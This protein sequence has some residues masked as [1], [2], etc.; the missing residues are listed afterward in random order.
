MR[1]ELLLVDN[2]IVHKLAQLDLLNETHSL[3]ESNYGELAV[4]ATLRYKFCNKHPAK[5]ARAEQKFGNGAIDNIQVFLDSNVNEIDVVVKDEKLLKAMSSNSR[6]LD[7]GEMQLLQTLLESRDDLMLTGDKKFLKSLSLN[8]DI[9]LYLP[10]LVELF[11]CFE[12]II[13]FIINEL[14]FTLVKDKYLNALNSGLQIDSTLRC[15]FEGRDKAQEK[16]V[17]DNLNTYISYLDKETCNLLSTN[18]RWRVI[19]KNKI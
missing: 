11:I 17:L 8:D 3:L 2:D 13:I 10:S 7:I 18:Q 12:Q 6:G 4:L 1:L 16:I 14:G 15:C 5:R 19:N 9:A